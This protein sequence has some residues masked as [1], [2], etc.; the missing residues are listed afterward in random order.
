MAAVQDRDGAVGM[1][2]EVFGRL[3]YTDCLPGCGRGAGGGFQVQAQSSGVESGQ[4]KLAVS[5][6]LY[7]VQVPWLNQRLPIGEF[8]LGLAHVHGEGYGTGQ[9]RYVGKEAAG[10]RDGNHLTDCLLTRDADRYGAI[11]PAQ[12]WRSPLWRDSP[13]PGKECPP[14]DAADL[15]AGPLTAD[16]VA[17]W[18]R[19][20]PER[21]TVLARLLTVL[22]DPAGRR[23]VIVSDDPDEAVTWIVAATLLLPTRHALKVSFKVFSSIPLRA[24]HRVAAAPAALFPQI[25]PGRGGTAFILDARTCAA[26]EGEVSERAAFFTR[27]FTADGDPYDVV[28]AVELTNALGDPGQPLGGRN[29][30]LTAWALTRPDEPRA[31]MSALFRWLS[32]A[33][34]G[35]LDEHGPAV[36]AL[37]LDAAPTAEVLRWIDGA[38]ADKR[39]DADAAAV[40]GQLL[41]AELAEIR[42]G[43]GAILVQQVLPSARL[44]ASA[45]RD[46][47]SELSSTILL[48][49][50][51]QAD[52]LLCL[53]RRHGIAPDLA[54][55][56]QQRLRD[57]VTSWLDHPAGYHPDGWALRAEIL[58]YA[59]DELRHR[60]AAGGMRSVEGLIRRLR[61]YF[62]DRAD[63]SDPLDCNIQASLIAEAD[64]A[65]RIPRL[66]QLLTQIG[67]L[68]ESPAPAPVAATA[69]AGLQQALVQWGAV[70]G[71][72]AVT[73]LT[74]LP[75]SFDVDQAIS[76]RAAEQLAHMSQKPTRALL[77]F[78]DRLDK[79]G[80]AP[81]SGTL[82]NALAADKLVRI[83][84][85]RA[86][87]D[88][89]RTDQAFLDGTLNVIR[90]ADPA[91]VHARLDEVLDA[92]LRA[93][94]PQLGAFVLTE[95][96]SPL[97]RLLVDRWGRTLGTRDPVSDGRW[98]VSCLDYEDL[99]DRR[100]QQLAAVVRYFANTLS[101][102][103]FQVWYDEVARQVGPQKR[104]LWDWIFPQDTPRS[105]INLWR[106]RD[107]GRS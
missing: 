77:E 62:G 104:D 18:A 49:S 83:F 76:S 24:E 3:L 41:A 25:A 23:V 61:G 75:A 37:I 14:L 100:Q 33:G 90:Q 98:C 9:G 96:K 46:A 22:E 93:T 10:G 44:D 28:D 56:M 13:W 8:P 1:T 32:G 92:C 94:H 19:A 53:A 66:R 105:R 81:S 6:L 51:Q 70:D 15:E 71:E 102:E 58:D 82:A 39:L 78:L 43:R 40:R 89:T 11:R 68:A 95:L 27:K 48:A 67:Q 107:G 64:R 97:P 99:P 55:P 103:D 34:R 88:R 12:L 74:E 31:E 65:G 36:A 52:L 79:R 91:V 4:S 63:L 57:F 85:T 26:D 45:A 30:M 106:N 29:A 69:A 35:L 80:K 38:V 84:I 72:V 86:F 73:V 60:A 20:R 101:K 54:V 50:D 16:A 21:A 17:D 87:D 2:A 42:D 7:E 47:E 59:H 5:S